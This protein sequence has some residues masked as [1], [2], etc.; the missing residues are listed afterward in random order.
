V[1]DATDLTTVYRTPFV[2]TSAGT[3]NVTASCE[4]NI[5]HA[6]EI[7]NKTIFVCAV[8]GFSDASTYAIQPDTGYIHYVF[9]D[10]IQLPN[11][12]PSLPTFVFPMRISGTNSILKIYN[13]TNTTSTF[14]AT[15]TN[16][17][18]SGV[19]LLSTNTFSNAAWFNITNTFIEFAKNKF[20]EVFMLNVYTV[21]S[22]SVSNTNFPASTFTINKKGSA[23]YEIALT[24]VN[25]AGVPQWT[26]VISTSGTTNA[27]YSFKIIA[28]DERNVFVHVNTPVQGNVLTAYNSNGTSYSPPLDNSS[29]LTSAFNNIIVKYDSNGYVL[30]F[31]KVQANPVILYGDVT[32]LCYDSFSK[33]IL[34]ALKNSA[35]SSTLTIN[36]FNNNTLTLPSSDTISS[37]VLKLN[38]IG[39]TN[40]QKYFAFSING[41]VQ[42]TN[43]CTDTIGNMYSTISN[44][45]NSVANDTFKIYDGVEFSQPL[46]EPSIIVANLYTNKRTYTLVK[47]NNLGQAQWGVT[48]TTQQALNVL[49]NKTL[50]TD[51]KG[52]IYF[53]FYTNNTSFNVKD[54]SIPSPPE[55]VLDPVTITLPSGYT[56]SS[57]LLQF[58]SDGVFQG[59]CLFNKSIV[60]EINFWSNGVYVNFA[61]VTYPVDVTGSNVTTPITLGTSTKVGHYMVR[62]DPNLTPTIVGYAST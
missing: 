16:T 48:I 55:L 43:V 47:H 49:L 24:K 28:D 8:F 59:Y 25:A 12:P 52:N 4:F 6:T 23:F 62:V 56:G 13:S 29:A 57:A 31:S 9:T 1:Y 5:Q 30:G 40:A 38:N 37:Y 42:V 21:S 26:T 2:T 54:T 51:A 53:A 58:N 14:S 15:T 7:E 10:Q 19:A 36:D 11:N 27:L 44:S 18:L 39:Y 32:D 50:C 3:N 35:F 22:V 60:E 33:S 45:Q 17:T 61:R 34:F 41:F 20:N 46:G